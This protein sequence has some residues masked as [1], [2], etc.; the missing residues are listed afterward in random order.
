VR[1]FAGVD[2]LALE[3]NHDEAMER[4]SGRPRHLIARVL[5]RN[6]HL[7]N[8]QAAAVSRDIL[9]AGGGATLQSLVQ[10]HLSR[11]CNRP[12]LAAA[13]GRNALS[14]IAPAARLWTAS[15]DVPCGPIPI[16]PRPGGAS[17]SP[18]T[19]IPIQSVTYQPRLPGL[20]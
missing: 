1:A 5:G 12:E 15:Q 8:R 3:F 13:E 7:S 6:G 19:P 10:L 4:A 14:G 2:V 17:R 11:H 16:Y 18:G 20:D 9:S